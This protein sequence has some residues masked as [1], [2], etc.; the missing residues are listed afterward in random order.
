MALGEK[1]CGISCRTKINPKTNLQIVR[2]A[3]FYTVNKHAVELGLLADGELTTY[4]KA[5][6]KIERFS[7]EKEEMQKKDYRKRWRNLIK[8]NPEAGRNILFNIDSK[9]SLWL[10]KNDRKWY[11][12]NSPPSTYVSTNWKEKGRDCLKKVKEAVIILN[13]ETGKP[14]LMSLERIVRIT[15]LNTLLRKN[16]DQNIHFTMSYLAEH[17]EPEDEWRKRKI[18]WAVYELCN[19]GGTV[20]VSGVQTKS[21]ISKEMFVPL[22]EYAQLCIEKAIGTE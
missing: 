6:K 11:D 21:S 1:A 16:A 12:R 9:T 2:L 15:G 22:K 8:E 3:D 18:K 17:L 14:K 13:A 10:Q 7:L 5:H 19:E 20:S 4:K